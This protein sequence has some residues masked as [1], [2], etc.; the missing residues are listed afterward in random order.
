MWS[1]SARSAPL[2]STSAAWPISFPRKPALFQ[3]SSRCP[4]FFF[5]SHL[6]PH[7]RFL[8]APRHGPHHPGRGGSGKEI[9]AHP[10]KDSARRH[11]CALQICGETVFPQA[12]RLRRLWRP[13]ASRHGAPPLDGPIAPTLPLHPFLLHI[14]T[15][16]NLCAMLFNI[17]MSVNTRRSLNLCQKNKSSC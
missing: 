6:P 11:P 14:L 12:V 15:R 1:F 4:P 3:P 13:D 2:F 16:V 10:P 5:L 9:R 8:G 7:L 17:L